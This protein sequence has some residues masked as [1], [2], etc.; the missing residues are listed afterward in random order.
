MGLFRI[1]QDGSSAGGAAT[2]LLLGKSSAMRPR[3]TDRECDVPS[4][5]QTGFDDGLHRIVQDGS[6][7]GGAV[8]ATVGQQSSNV[9]VRQSDKQ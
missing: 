2:R 8:L 5:S 9:T 4:D 3:P 6:S 7:A 1:V